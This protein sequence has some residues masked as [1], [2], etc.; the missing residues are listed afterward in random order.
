M[1]K[2]FEPDMLC[3]QVAAMLADCADLFLESRRK[4]HLAVI[5]EQTLQTAHDLNSIL[6]G[7]MG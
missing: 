2:P 6:S 7:A 3:T 5:G 1:D 4:E